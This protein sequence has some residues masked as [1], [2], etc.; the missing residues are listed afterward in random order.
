MAISEIGQK[1]AALTVRVVSSD[2]RIGVKVHNRGNITVAIKSEEE[3]ARYSDFS[4]LAAQI[5]GAMNMAM[6]QYEAGRL[7]LIDR[8]HSMTTK[9]PLHWRSDRRQLR[10]ELEV[11]RSQAVSPQR[12]VRIRARGMKKFKVELKPE[13]LNEITGSQFAQEINH[14]LTM[15]QTDHVRARYDLKKAYVGEVGMETTKD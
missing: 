4:E 3:Y 1:F 13:T 10:E 2:G 14:T 9:G 8:S 5:T 7:E 12:L 11:V 15:L 6:S